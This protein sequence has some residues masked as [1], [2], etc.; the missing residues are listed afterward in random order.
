LAF[1]S[2]C[3]YQEGGPSGYSQP[4]TLCFKLR[5]VNRENILPEKNNRIIL[6]AKAKGEIDCPREDVLWFDWYDPSITF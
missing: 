3:E 4:M 1:L 5:N 6:E 2:G